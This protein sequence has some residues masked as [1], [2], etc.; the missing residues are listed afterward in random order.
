[1]NKQ[2]F[3]Q[4]KK[5]NGTKVVWKNEDGFHFSMGED[6]MH[7]SDDDEF[8][9]YDRIQQ[10]CDKTA[11]IDFAVGY[12]DDT[13]NCISVKE[14]SDM[15]KVEGLEEFITTYVGSNCYTDE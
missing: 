8:D 13:V 10:A 5:E 9:N 7:L 15:N 1:M 14:L 6:L 2:E 12:G 3:N 4:L 11:G